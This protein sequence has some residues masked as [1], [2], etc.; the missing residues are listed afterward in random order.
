MVDADALHVLLAAALG[1]GVSV[2]VEKLMTPQ[3]CSMRHRAWASIALH[4]GIWLAISALLVLLLG[5]PWFALAAQTA[6]LLL[7]VVVNNAKVASLR[8]PF[9][10]QDHE[11][12]TDAILHPRLYIPFLGWGKAAAAAMGFASAVF[13]GLWLEHIPVNRWVWS[14]QLGGLTFVFACAVL[15]LVAGNFG[16]LAPTFDPVHD[17]RELGLLASLW[18]YAKAE[19]IRPA[20]SSAFASAPEPAEGLIRPHLVA[21][22]SESFFD[23]RRFVSGIQS[24]ALVEFDA[25]KSSALA[26][27]RLTVPAWGANTVRSEF[28]FLSGVGSAALDVHRFNP[29]RKVVRWG[30]PTL[31]SYLK[32]LGYRTICVH[33]Y[34]AGFYG[35]DQMY[36]LM[37]FDEFIDI[38]A[39]TDADRSG[40]YVGDMAVAKKIADILES[41]TEP[42][43][44]HAI[45]ME[46]HGPLH[47]EKVTAADVANLYSQPPPPSCDDLTAYLKHLRNA[48]LMLAMLK[49]TLMG[50]PQPASLC[51][52]GDHVPIMEQVYEALGLP[53]GETEYL[54]WCNAQTATSEASNLEAHQLAINWLQRVGLMG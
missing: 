6:L 27:G 5:R 14:G 26:H 4:G 3:P 9:V 18:C 33:P 28:A 31:A 1:L 37:G 25:L 29:Y 40:A 16:K 2:G 17:V 34:P 15:L 23:P 30:V 13:V 48:D 52:F 11:Y 21:V 24:N 10:F 45:T 51:W 38:R 47:L 20:L 35:R 32:Q 44:V 46:N 39:F 53:D 41:A 8:E 12:F 19:R 22:Q 7:I 54:L 36:P 42:V 43:F 50:L 49:D